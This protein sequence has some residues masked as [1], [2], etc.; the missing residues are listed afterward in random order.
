MCRPGGIAWPAP[1]L[2]RFVELSGKLLTRINRVT[3]CV[4]TGMDR[5]QS[6][7]S[8][9]LRNGGIV[10][11]KRIWIINHYANH[12]SLPGGT[13][14][15]EQRGVVGTPLC[16]EERDTT[17]LPGGWW[18]TALTSR[19]CVRRFITRCMHRHGISAVLASS[20]KPMG[21]GSSGFDPD[22]DTQATAC[23]GFSA[24]SN[25]P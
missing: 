23:G 22:S 5:P 17:S 9:R 25:S 2:Q 3:N 24:W 12:P 8:V 1:N 21:C 11:R 10:D 15:Y 6:V 4:Y 18:R 13:R 14:H 20:R 16:P 19:F 7:S